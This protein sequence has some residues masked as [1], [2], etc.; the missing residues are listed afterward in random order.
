MTPLQWVCDILQSEMVLPV[1]SVYL[2]NQKLDLPSDRNLYIA[3][4]VTSMKCFGNSDVTENHAAGLLERQSANYLATLS[5]DILSRGTQAR[6]RK[7]EILMAL[8]SAYSQ[9]V[10]QREGFYIATVAKTFVNL[11]E[12]EGAAI[13]YRFSIAVNIQYK[14]V[15]EKLTPYYDAFLDP[16]VTTE[17]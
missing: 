3:V 16:Q 5:I 1:G 12:I 6:D 14:V 15:K 7:E 13:P 10:Q 9:Q 11:S 8:A 17:A 2:W 4:G